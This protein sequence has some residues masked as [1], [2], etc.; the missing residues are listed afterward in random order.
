[1]SIHPNPS[2][3]FLEQRDVPAA[4]ESGIILTGQS[5]PPRTFVSAIHPHT[6]DAMGLAV[7]DEVV[8]N[9]YSTRE[10]HVDQVMRLVVSASDILAKIT[11][12]SV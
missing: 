11:E 7:G 12:V 5:A 4:T 10:I 2:I 1:M 8:V 3:I 9:P 6:A